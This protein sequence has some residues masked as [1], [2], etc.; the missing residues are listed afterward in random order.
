MWEATMTI[1]DGNGETFYCARATDNYP[2]KAQGKAYEVLCESE[3]A[4]VRIAYPRDGDR[5]VVEMRY[6]P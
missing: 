3:R 1:I 4:R 5:I 6:A 2:F